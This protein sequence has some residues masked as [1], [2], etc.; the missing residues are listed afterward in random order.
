MNLLVLI[1][2]AC[3]ILGLLLFCYHFNRAEHIELGVFLCIV[4]LVIAIFGIYLAVHSWGV[5]AD[6]TSS[7]AVQRVRF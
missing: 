4:S 6:K 3:T 7:S 1:G 2:L 5:R